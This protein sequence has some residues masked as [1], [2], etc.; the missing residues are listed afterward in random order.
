[1]KKIIAMIVLA[2]LL[3]SGCAAKS[4]YTSGN[5]ALDAQVTALLRDAGAQ[6]GQDAET[7]LRAA[8]DYIRDH[9]TYLG[10]AQYEAGTDD[11]TEQAAEQMFAKKKGNCFSFAAAFL[12]CARQLGFQAH[13][14]AGWRGAEK[15]PHAWVMIDFPD[16][17]SYL[18]DVLQEYVSLHVNKDQKPDK[19]FK[20]LPEDAPE[21]YIFP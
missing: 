15:R 8:Y 6:S 16:G 11:W 5:K 18:F 19:L 13:A 1:M 12:Y 2:A 20:I 7:N 21:K 14:V 3:L 4:E 9:F 10:T 17:K